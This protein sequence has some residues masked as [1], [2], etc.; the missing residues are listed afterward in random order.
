MRQSID[1]QYR[2]TGICSM[3][4]LAVVF[5]CV[6]FASFTLLPSAVAMA[7]E[8]VST[9]AGRIA[10]GGRLYDKW[11]AVIGAEKLTDT[12]TA[13]PAS[14]TKKKGDTTWRCKSC[15]GWDNMGKDGAYASGSYQTGI[16]GV[17]GLAGADQAK[18]I[19]LIKDDT[20]GLAGKMD[21]QDFADLALFIS[22]GLTDMDKYIDRAT[23]A[24][25]GDKA[26][27][28]VYYETVCAN[29]HGAKGT[30][31]KDMDPLGKLMGNPWEILHKIRYGQPKEQM[32]ALVAF[33][34]QVAADIMAYT[35]TLPKE[36]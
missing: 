29:C 14:N 15:H 22:V 3:G 33:D 27:G 17:R 16:T 30:K 19:A 18:I 24:P 35:A 9:D 5:V 10:R 7:E 31:V 8:A 28:Q 32:P 20:H 6:V 11:Y 2:L 1:Q 13:W 12:H 23:K 21:D 36:K 34:P 4:L 26:K 25:K